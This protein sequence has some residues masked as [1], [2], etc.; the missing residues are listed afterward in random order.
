MWYH[1]LFKEWFLNS[2]EVPSKTTDALCEAVRKHNITCRY[3]YFRARRKNM[4]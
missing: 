3:W 4:L 2:V 1:E